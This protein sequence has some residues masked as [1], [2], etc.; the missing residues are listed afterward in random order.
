M[1]S[2]PASERLRSLGRALGAFR[3]A[4][5]EYASLRRE[6]GNHLSAWEGFPITQKGALGV[7]RHL[8]IELT[9]TGA[10]VSREPQIIVANHLSW[11][12]PIALLTFAPA[13]FVARAD[14]R[15]WPFFGPHLAALGTI[16]VERKS[17]ASR[18]AVRERI[19]K[20][21]LEEKR[22]VGVFPEGTT[23][24]AGLPWRRGVFE[25]AK[26]GNIPIQAFR[27]RYEPVREVAYVDDD[28]FHT[29]FWR[30]LGLPRIR[31]WIELRE[32]M[33]VD[34]PERARLELE[35]WTREWSRLMAAP[36]NG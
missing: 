27:I 31:A 11:L 25:V 2:R 7:F 30:V 12:D 3:Q 13:S 15:L 6:R 21:V 34:D 5:I 35:E 22:T 19:L 23:S 24:I 16:F 33:R 36:T 32:P 26:Q 9:I 18:T 1:S 4:G 20:A 8:G 29:Q 28:T 14:T 17:S 10:S